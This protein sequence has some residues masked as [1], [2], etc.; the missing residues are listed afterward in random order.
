MVLTV[1][2]TS[3]GWVALPYLWLV[4]VLAAVAVIDLR[5]WLIPWWMPWVGAAVGFVLICAM[6]L[7]IGAPD[8]IVRAVISGVVMFGLFFVLW[9]VAPGKLGFGD[10]RLMFLLGLFLGWFSLALPICRPVR[11]PH[12]TR[13]GVGRSSPPGGPVPVRL[14]ALAPDGP[15]AQRSAAQQPGDGLRGRRDPGGQVVRYSR[16]AGTLDIDRSDFMLRWAPSPA[17]QCTVWPS[18]TSVRERPARS[19]TTDARSSR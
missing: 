10:V 13:H 15:V 4:V 7:V 1:A 6:S 8:A 9:L 5:I 12:R 11:Q 18:G 17:K 16:S 2:T 3:S 19:A 14:L